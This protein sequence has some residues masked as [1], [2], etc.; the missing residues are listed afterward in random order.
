MHDIAFL[1]FYPI[2]SRARETPLGFIGGRSAGKSF[3][4]RVA[5]KKSKDS[6]FSAVCFVSDRF[7]VADQ[8]RFGP[9]E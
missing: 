4:K 9:R 8:T 2:T 1:L 6:S 5:Y 7:M 3:H